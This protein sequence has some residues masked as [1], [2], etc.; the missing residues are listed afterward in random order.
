MLDICFEIEREGPILVCNTR[1]IVPMNLH[2][3]QGVGH[4]CLNLNFRP[5]LTNIQIQKFKSASA[6]F[7]IATKAAIYCR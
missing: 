3:K 6:T 2:G 4:V 7:I 5:N 1:V